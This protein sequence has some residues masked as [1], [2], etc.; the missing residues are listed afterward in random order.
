MYS[1]WASAIWYLDEKILKT[2]KTIWPLKL[3]SGKTLKLISDPSYT[4][5]IYIIANNDDSNVF[6]AL[7]MII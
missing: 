5:P 1:Y 3:F 2:V 6:T 4:I 7:S